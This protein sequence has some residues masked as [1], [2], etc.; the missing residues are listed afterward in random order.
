MLRKKLLQTRCFL[1]HITGMLLQARLINKVWW[2]FYVWE[3]HKCCFGDYNGTLGDNTSWMGLLTT[4]RIQFIFIA[5]LITIAL[6]I[7][8]F[9]RLKYVPDTWLHGLTSCRH[10]VNHKMELYH[11]GKIMIAM[12]LY[13]LFSLFYGRMCCNLLKLMHN[14]CHSGHQILTSIRHSVMTNVQKIHGMIPSVVW[15]AEEIEFLT[16]HHRIR[17]PV[18]CTFLFFMDP[19]I[20]FHKVLIKKSKYL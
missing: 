11:K 9:F 18:I 17:W 3:E 2:Q 6:L 20:Q 7:T 14:K 4:I 16:P 13:T 1:P 8:I 12:R 5:K 10:N 19:D 15:Q